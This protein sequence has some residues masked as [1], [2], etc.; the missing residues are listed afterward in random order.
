MKNHWG[1]SPKSAA[2]TARPGCAVRTRS[3]FPEAEGN[4]TRVLKG[5]LPCG[6]VRAAAAAAAAR[7]RCAGAEPMPWRPGL[8]HAGSGVVMPCSCAPRPPPFQP[9]LASSCKGS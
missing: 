4:A 7:L 3:A 1:I 6:G 2:S 8:C 5:T 9:A